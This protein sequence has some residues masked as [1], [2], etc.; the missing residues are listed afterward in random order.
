MLSLEQARQEQLVLHDAVL[1]P[2]AGGL[3]SAM[4]VSRS[5]ETGF[6]Q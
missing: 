5:S 2:G 1:E 3:A 6:S 4:A